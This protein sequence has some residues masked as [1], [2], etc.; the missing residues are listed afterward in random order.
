LIDFAGVPVEMNFHVRLFLQSKFHQLPDILLRRW[1]LY[2][3]NESVPLWPN[4]AIRRER[5][6]VDEVLDLP[7]GLLVEGC[8]AASQGVDEL[9]Q[10]GIRK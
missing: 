8:N 9:I 1:T 3:G 2:G 5:G 10:F 4:L 7:D 6:D